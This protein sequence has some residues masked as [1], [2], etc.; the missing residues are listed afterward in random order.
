IIQLTEEFRNRILY[1]KSKKIVD[2]LPKELDEIPGDEI[3][4]RDLVDTIFRLKSKSEYKT[5]AKY[6]SL[7]LSSLKHVPMSRISK[8]KNKVNNYY[9]KKDID[10]YIRSLTPIYNSDF[11]LVH[12]FNYEGNL[13]EIPYEDLLFL[14]EFKSFNLKMKFSYKTNIIPLSCTTMINFLGGRDTLSIF[15]KYNLKENENEFSKISTHVPRHNINTFLALSGL[16]EHLQ[17]MLMGRVDI[18]QNQYYQHLALKQRKVAASILDKKDLV[19][20][21]EKNTLTSSITP[22]NSVLQDGLL[23]FSKHGDLENN[24]KMNL[25]SF[26]SRNEVASY[27]KESFFD[28]YF[29]DISA[30][31]NELSSND[32]KEADLLIYRH[33]YCHP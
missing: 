18:K 9:F 6:R 8:G 26:D 12:V 19:L 30:A 24:L 31:F 10:N 25:Q 28:E 32:P 1:V 29:D 23:Y 4:I 3:E 17:A 22:V 2:F 13:E 27:I 33:A 16:S 14:S 11:P 20:V 7:I 15:E 21:K 5:R